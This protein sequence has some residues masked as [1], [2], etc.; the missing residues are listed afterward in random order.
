MR[1]WVAEP[2]YSRLRFRRFNRIAVSMLFRL[3]G[4]GVVVVEMKL[5]YNGD[6]PTGQ[7]TLRS[8][9][10]P[11]ADLGTG[12]KDSW[13]GQMQ[14]LLIGGFSGFSSVERRDTPLV[15]PQLGRDSRA[16]KHLTISRLICRPV[17]QSTLQLTYTRHHKTR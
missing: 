10:C 16:T 8:T 14:G 6:S 11:V 4:V 2:W 15:I 1:R 5:E 7:R 3:S 13:D 9:K 12:T 17:S